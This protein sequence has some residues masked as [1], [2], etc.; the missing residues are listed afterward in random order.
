[1]PMMQELHSTPAS[2]A[3]GP[4]DRTAIDERY[5]WN[6]LDIFSD[7]RQWETACRE[8][9][10]SIDLFAG[11]QGA[12]AQSPGNLL[13]ALQIMDTAGQL[14]YK[15]WYFVALKYDEDQRNNEANAKR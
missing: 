14:A 12:L 9:S 3:A 13:R 10:E 1:M 5:T 7:W 2:T 15:V 4:Q 6:L 11:L 8:L